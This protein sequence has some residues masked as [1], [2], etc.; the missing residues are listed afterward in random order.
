MV[1]KKKFYKKYFAQVLIV[2]KNNNFKKNS[3]ID[4]CEIYIT[5]LFA[6]TVNLILMDVNLES[7]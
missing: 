2:L 7:G 5:C 3:V 4:H 1:K 6:A